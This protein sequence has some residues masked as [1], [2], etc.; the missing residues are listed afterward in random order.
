MTSGSEFAV[1][2]SVSRLTKSHRDAPRGAK[3]AQR[4]VQVKVNSVVEL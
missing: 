3:V 4:V 2:Q 1:Q